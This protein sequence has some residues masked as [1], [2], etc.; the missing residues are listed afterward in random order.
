MNQ[1]L[2]D[3]IA[4]NMRSLRSDR[5]MSQRDLAREA[6]V[7]Y[8]AVGLWELAANAISTENLV[9]VADALNVSVTRLIGRD[10]GR[11]FWDGYE[12]GWAACRAAV[13]KAAEP[14]GPDG[15]Q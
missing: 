9:A 5:G 3:T 1:Q 6:G 11:E 14:A 8:A 13:V 12:T 4:A 15:G 7:S 2:A 10:N